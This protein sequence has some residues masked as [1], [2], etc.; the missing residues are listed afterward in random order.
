MTIATTVSSDSVCKCTLAAQMH[1][2]CSLE[3]SGA[4]HSFCLVWCKA[5]RLSV[6]N[7]ARTKS[8]SELA[9]GRKHKARDEFAPGSIPGA[10]CLSFSVGTYL[11]LTQTTALLSGNLSPRRPCS[12]SRVSIA[13][14]TSPIRRQVAVRVGVGVGSDKL[15]KRR[16]VHAILRN[17]TVRQQKQ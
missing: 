12:W 11:T 9:T 6:T 10:S 17:A 15:L 8:Q 5:G 1:F 13:F 2:S 4:R 14:Q 3:A 7:N 16:H